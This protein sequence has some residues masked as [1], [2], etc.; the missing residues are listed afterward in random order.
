MSAAA[1]WTIRPLAAED[2]HAFRAI[3]LDALRLHPR[4]FGTSYEEEVVYTLDDYAEGWPAPPGVILGGL[5]GDRLVGIAG[6]QL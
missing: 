2:L 1:P 4:A 3:R 5:V 6:L